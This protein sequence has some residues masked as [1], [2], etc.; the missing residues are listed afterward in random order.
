[1]CGARIEMNS[2]RDRVILWAVELLVVLV[3]ILALLI[4]LKHV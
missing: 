2:N 4:L 3:V 1:M